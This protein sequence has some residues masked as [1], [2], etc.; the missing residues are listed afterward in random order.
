MHLPL[1]KILITL[2]RLLQRFRHTAQES[3][4]LLLLDEEFEGVFEDGADGAAAEGH[5]DV[6]A[7]EEEAVDFPFF[8]TGEDM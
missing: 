4:F 1:L 5:G 2:G 6:F 3:D 7:V 8:G